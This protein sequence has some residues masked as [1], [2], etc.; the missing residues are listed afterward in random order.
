MKAV[1]AISARVAEELG[2]GADAADVLFAVLGR[3][4]QP[5]SL[6][7]LL[8]VPLLE[9]ARPGVQAVADVVAVE[10]EA[11]QARANAACGRPGSRP[12]SCRR[13]SGR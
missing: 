13:R 4:T 6:G 9:H 10:H 2:H 8:A 12:C 11:V 7:E 1:M 5:E 3:K